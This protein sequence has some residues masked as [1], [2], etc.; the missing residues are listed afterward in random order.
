MTEGPIVTPPPEE[1][2]LLPP[3]IPP[4]PPPPRTS[5]K[6]HVWIA[7]IAFFLL[8]G[9]IFLIYWL[10]WGQFEESTNDAY[11]NGNMIMITP[12]QTGIVTSILADNTQ[13]VEA[14][15]PLV[16][17]DR[18]DY[19]IAFEQSKADLADTVRKVVGMFLKVDELKAKR[20][21]SKAELIKT[22]LDFEHRK[23]LVGD[24]SVSRED[25]EH[26]E[27]ALYAAFSGL[28]EVEK[29]LEGAY[30][31]V[32]NTTVAAHPRVDQAK[33]ALR[34]AF[35]GLHRC[36]VLAPARGIITLRKAQVGQWVK[37]EDALMALVPVE[38]M[39]V[40]AN[41][42][43]VSLKH[44]RIGQ[45]VRLVSDMYGSSD[46]FHGKIVGL[47]PG[48]GS[49]FSILPPQN[50]TGNWI[51]IVQRVPVK[52]S[53]DPDELCA[54]PLVLGLSMTVTADTHDRDGLRLPE[55]TCSEPLYVSD[56]YADELKGVE[57]IIDKI[58]AANSPE[59]TYDSK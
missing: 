54:Y 12:Q 47:N 23:A 13:L 25:Y 17:L 8:C 16:E 40:D 55:A 5:R 44:L 30:A 11:V 50:A 2:K 32:V 20:E 7:A 9:L 26:S 33:S 48:T 35:L 38:Q 15:Q 10:I 6:K 53:L 14:G 51:K 18:H 27:T 28:L 52:I 36:T 57:Q 24:G 45:P 41:F 37:A 1:Q 3:P 29:E 39:W 43:E 58:I 31:E 56:V 4:S 49:V 21:V 34:K 22:S 59:P 19:E 42:R 46:T